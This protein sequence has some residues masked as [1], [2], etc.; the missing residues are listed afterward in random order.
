MENTKNTL[1][2][3]TLLALLT[4]YLLL[5]GCTSKNPTLIESP[6]SVTLSS[7]EQI[8]SFN[9][10]VACHQAVEVINNNPYDQEFFETVFAKLIDQCKNSKS[11]DN[12]DII[13][14]HFVMP[15]RETGKVPPDLAKT[16][17]N[18]YF[19]REFFSLPDAGTVNHYCLRLPQIKKN[20]EKE[21]TLKK[22]GFEISRQG[23]PDAH[24]LN[25]MY[26]FNTM[27]AGCHEVK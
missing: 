23:S 14:D 19:S 25:A 4:L 12:A 21:F 24:F 26:V 22:D 10:E 17:W 27:W 18:Y 3:V 13:W 20:L 1:L 5:S 2:F 7:V 11:T 16:V 6:D 9:L 8:D 15:L